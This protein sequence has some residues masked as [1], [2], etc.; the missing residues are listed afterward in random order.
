MQDFKITIHFRAKNYEKATKAF[1]AVLE[2]KPKR[3]LASFLTALPT[4]ANDTPVAVDPKVD[5]F[6]AL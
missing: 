2:R 6:P 3:Y 5:G 4:G 1:A